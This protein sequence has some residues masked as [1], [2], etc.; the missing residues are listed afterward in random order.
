MPD[1]DPA[2]C[3]K[4]ENN[5]RY[6]TPSAGGNCAEFPAWSTRPSNYME[7]GRQAAGLPRTTLG[8][9]KRVE[10]CGVATATQ[11]SKTFQSTFEKSWEKLVGKLVKGL[12][13]PCRTCFSSSMKGPCSQHWQCVIGPPRDHC[14]LTSQVNQ[15]RSIE[16]MNDERWMIGNG[17]ASLA[18]RVSQLYGVAH[19]ACCCS[20]SITWPDRLL[21]MSWGRPARFFEGNLSN[22]NRI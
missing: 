8:N 14:G 18:Y 10:L 2:C 17:T 1:R 21:P 12:A 15:F 20:L 22:L 7:H 13:G 6:L 16:R 3:F 19:W 4:R 5:S 11:H 9:I